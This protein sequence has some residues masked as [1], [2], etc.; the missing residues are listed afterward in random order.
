MFERGSFESLPSHLEIAL[1]ILDDINSRNTPLAGL[2]LNTYRSMYT[3]TGDAKLALEYHKQVRVIKEKL[4]PKR[5][6][7]VSNILHNLALDHPADGNYR[8]A[9]VLCGETI[10]T[11]EELPDETHAWYKAHALPKN[12]T[13]YCRIF[14][15]S[16]GLENAEITCRKALELALKGLGIKHQNTAQ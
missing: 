10:S 12:Y 13:T 4:L 1:R 15:M 14:H 16:G 3:E 9:E 5:D 2:I 7:V 8:E 11:R 6:P